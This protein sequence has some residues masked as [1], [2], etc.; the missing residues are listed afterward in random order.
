MIPTFKSLEQIS[1]G[2]TVFEKDQVLTHEQL[3][4]LADYA[5]DQIRLTRVRLLGTGIACG[6]RAYVSDD[7]VAVSK[8]MGVTTDGDIITIERVTYFTRF[9]QYDESFPAYPGL[10]YDGD[11]ASGMMPAYELLTDDTDAGTSWPLSEFPLREGRGLTSMVVVLLMESY[12]KDDDICSGTDCD[13]LGKEAINRMRCILVDEEGASQLMANLPG[14]NSG[15]GAISPILPDRPV[16][17]SAVNSPSAIGSLYRTACTSLHGKIMTEFAWL[18]GSWRPYLDEPYNP[19]PISSWTDKMESIRSSFA[20]NDIGIQYYYDFL[21]D[22]A[23]TY[24]AMRELLFGNMT[25]CLPNFAAFPKHL[26]L[27]Y[28]IDGPPSDDFR[29]G[30]YPS[31]ITAHTDAEREHAEFL[32][33]KLDMMIRN[34][35]PP[36]VGTTDI[37]ITPSSHEDVT[38]EERAIPFYYP[39]SSANRLFDAWNFR[40]SRRGRGALNYSYNAAAYA[41]AGGVSDPFRLQIGRFPF[42]RIEGHLGKPV[43]TALARIKELI[44]TNNVPIAVRAIMAGT[45]RA[46]VTVK[47]AMRSDALYSVHRV[48]RQD[49]ANQLDDVKLFSTAFNGKVQAEPSTAVTSA[50]DCDCPSI[51]LLS[52]NSS[53][54][55]VSRAAVVQDKLVRNYTAYA[56]DTSWQTSL[57]NT[58]E[59]A[60]QFK[61]SLSAVV[62][63]DFA[64][65]YDTLISSTH[66]TLLPL[67][68]QVIKQKEERADERLLLGTFID[69]N[70][71][72]EHFAGVVRG[73]TFLLVYD[74]TNTVI[75]DFMVPYYLPEEE[76]EPVD[77]L[78]L[79]KP[80][81]RPAYVIDSGIKVQPSRNTFINTK[82]DAAVGQVTANVVGVM[83]TKFAQ[84]NAIVDGKLIQQNAVVDGKIFQQ[85]ASVDRKIQEQDLK[86][87]F[88]GD[89][90]N[91]FRDSVQMLGSTVPRADQLKSATPGTETPA[92]N[93]PYLAMRVD[94]NVMFAGKITV[95]QQL[96]SDMTLDEETRWKYIQEA[97][98][99]EYMLVDSII[100]ILRYIVSA[101]MSVIGDADGGRAVAAIFPSL[102]SLSNDEAKENLRKGL[103]EVIASTGDKNIH[104]VCHNM[105]NAI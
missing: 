44:K 81:V 67:L 77:D 33:G 66:A 52:A 79:V 25:Q 9:R 4:S 40:L 59:T 89:Y 29:T 92:I 103:D 84:H 71:G 30:F 63:T 57:K 94:E 36:A 41:S 16:L 1:T 21:K 15:L 72:V 7:G 13:N 27:G 62:K 38:L 24:N 14:V 51:R 64:T 54:D 76:V 98:Q 22:I 83:D 58:M 70:P 20:T 73:G 11:I 101:R 93:D 19:F 17:T 2:Y 60:G 31:P 3:N 74:A 56:A 55:V 48:L 32:V 91:L 23:E 28:V 86:V 65:P 80:A 100:T 61:A 46:Q 104:T 43:A 49:L 88:Q 34:F 18:S 53:A 87:S 10:Y 85:T 47:P 35:A 37:R 5:D 39:A 50:E 45:N 102:S 82:L 97:Q 95:L 99:T 105:M 42:F 75:A 96:A 68:D 90:V 78:T 6:L 12:R 69:R 8:G 26:L